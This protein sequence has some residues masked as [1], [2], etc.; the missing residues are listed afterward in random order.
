MIPPPPLPLSQ[1]RCTAAEAIRNVLAIIKKDRNSVFCVV[2]FRRIFIL[3]VGGLF[4]VI[5]NVSRFEILEAQYFL[6]LIYRIMISYQHYER[7][8]HSTVSCWWEGFVESMG[9]IRCVSSPI[10]G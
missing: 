10:V 3:Q 7:S 9:L 1:V 2:N 8:L 6:D 5:T 4:P